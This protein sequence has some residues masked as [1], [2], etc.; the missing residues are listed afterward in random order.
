M[1][2]I[3]KLNKELEERRN[4][5]KTDEAKQQ[6]NEKFKKYR[7]SLGGKV[8][9]KI[10]KESGQLLKITSEG[11]KKAYSNAKVKQKFIE[12]GKKQGKKNA[13]SG[14]LDSIRT[15]EGCE[16]GGKIGFEKQC[17]ELICPVC[18]ASGKGRIMYKWHFDNCKNEKI[19]QYDSNEN[20]IK[21]WKSYKELSEAGFHAP[22]I[23]YCCNGKKS[24]YKGFIWKLEK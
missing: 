5:N 1:N 9:G 13:E 4:I 21:K 22:S 7:A 2:W 20:L 19:C 15:K 10:A 14:F 3:D 11:G 12:S 6:A 24:H 17:I 18:G 16:L 8:A 23:S